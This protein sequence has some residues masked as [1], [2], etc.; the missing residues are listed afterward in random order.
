MAVA[1]T[2]EM[3][4][5]ARAALPELPAQRSARLAG[6]F[7]LNPDAARLLAFRSEL[8]DF[9]EAALTADGAHPRTLANWVTGELVSLVATVTPRSAPRAGG[10]RGAGGHGRGRR[11]VGLRG[12]GGA[13]RAGGRGWR[14]ARG[15]ASERGLA[16]AGGD[17]LGAIVDQALA[18]NADAVEKIKGGNPKA[19]GAIVGRGDEGH[20]GGRRRR[21]GAAS[22][23]RAHRGLRPP[24]ST[25]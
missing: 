15:G 25:G 2:E 18:D 24:S 21:G 8:G 1:P 11:G 17:E 9:Y 19:I 20:E 4:E 13:R 12:Q 6:A 5:R 3:L 16:K 23:P 10:A 22:R 7:G 14:P